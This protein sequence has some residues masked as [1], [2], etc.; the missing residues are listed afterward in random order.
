MLKLCAETAAGDVFGSENGGNDHHWL[1]CC[2]RT[3]MNERAESAVNSEWHPKPESEPWAPQEYG[4][5]SATFQS[6]YRSGSAGC[7]LLVVPVKI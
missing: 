4:T 2:V 7:G 5:F 6:W 1:C 3:G